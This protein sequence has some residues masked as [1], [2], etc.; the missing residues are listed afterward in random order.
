MDPPLS[1]LSL[2]RSVSGPGPTTRTSFVPPPSPST[3]TRSKRPKLA[4]PLD[5]ASTSH[6]SRSAA[7]ASSSIG[8]KK[9]RKPLG[10]PAAVVGRGG[11]GEGRK[12]K[13][14]MMMDEEEQL[15]L[16][17]LD[18]EDGDEEEEEK[19]SYV[20]D[21]VGIKREELEAETFLFLSQAYASLRESMIARVVDPFIDYAENH[22]SPTN[23]TLSHLT[24]HLSPIL[25]HLKPLLIRRTLDVLKDG[26]EDLYLITSP[27]C[28]EEMLDREEFIYVRFPNSFS[29]LLTSSFLPPRLG[30]ILLLLV[31]AHT[32]FLF[33]PRP[34]PRHP[35]EPCSTP[36]TTPN[37]PTP[38]TSTSLARPVPEG[39]QLG[40]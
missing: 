9:D 16:R 31:V 23:P 38:P 36:C 2:K 37:S 3:S 8:V 21:L 1:T 13:A 25:A 12:G 22:T 34:T 33:S 26:D 14:R 19:N 27:I 39:K 30:S 20:W 15:E 4:S 5:L 7:K 35:S 18:N 32:S 28:T 17:R 40:T 29:L 10:K 6:S 24:A 11:G